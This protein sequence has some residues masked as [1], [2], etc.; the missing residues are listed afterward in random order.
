MTQSTPSPSASTRLPVPQDRVAY[1]N[2]STD[3]Y[4]WTELLSELDRT[5]TEFT[6]VL[7][8]QQDNRWARFV[9]VRGEMRGGVGGAG[10]DVTLEAAMRAL[11][12]SYISLAHV[13]PLI[14][15]II[16][17]CRSTP[18]RPLET[19]WPDA[20]DQLSRERFFGALISGSNCSFWEAGRVVTGSLPQTDVPCLV[21]SPLTSMDRDSLVAFWQELI[22]ITH[23]YNPEFD[24]T[25]K[26]VT[27]Q[28]SGRYPILDPFV[29]DI[30]VHKG[31]LHVDQEVPTVDLRPALLA[32]FQ[33]TL[34]RLGIRL[35][36]L[37]IDTLI[38]HPG[39][40]AAGLEVL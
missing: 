37:P 27:I 28:L 12:K 8:M 1:S 26:Q 20:Y 6:A 19:M 7:D 2:L 35:K 32:A 31:R 29:R 30:A 23:E 39:W 15:E 18:P 9:W 14:A 17:K 22:A 33:T 38:S 10:R 3:F 34:S 21:V 16:W 13:E 36:E 5:D 11:P 25:W 4:P 40:L 24:E